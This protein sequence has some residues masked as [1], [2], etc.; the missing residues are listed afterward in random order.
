M[1]T[2]G[3]VS[4]LMACYNGER[5]IER[6]FTSILNQTWP[7]I[8]LVFVDD[9][10][11]DNSVAVAKSYADVFAAKGYELV[12]LAQEKQ[13]FAAAAAWKAAQV[14]SGEFFQL[15]DVDDML[16]PESCQ[17]QAEFLIS[18]QDCDLIRTNGYM[19]PA[20]NL[21]YEGNPLV[22]DESEK[23]SRN[24]FK[25]LVTG[26]ANNWA[27][28]F[29]LRADK[30]REFYAEKQ[31]YCTAFGQNL[32]FLMPVA[33]NS[34]AGFIDLPLFKYIRNEGSHSY[35]PTYEKQIKNLD[36]YWDIRRHM[37]ELLE[38]KDVEL[39]RSCEA[40]YYSRAMQ[41]ALDFKKIENYN[42]YYQKLQ[43]FQSPT[44]VQKM[45]NAILN[46]DIKQYWYRLQYKLSRTK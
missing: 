16:M 35:Q 40:A 4:I 8:E 12:V 11:T 28:A 30:F 42:Q 18:H 3:K 31:F 22:K 15:L 36:G 5:F 41:I 46:K 20:D 13:G 45:E 24:I 44:L 14:A 2:K 6:S 1:S 25:E 23:L 19:V 39:L 37:I 9:A 27:G 38:I 29:M 26:K 21:F 7:A 32:Q 17:K 43:S 10:S 34:N 33:L